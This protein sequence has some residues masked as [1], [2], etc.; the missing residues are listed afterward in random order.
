MSSNGEISNQFEQIWN[1][2]PGAVK[3]TLPSLG[4]VV[5]QI[6]NT[7]IS[8]SEAKECSDILHYLRPENSCSVKQ[9]TASVEKLASNSTFFEANKTECV[10]V[11]TSKNVECPPN[12]GDE[13]T[14]HFQAIANKLLVA[15]CVAGAIQ[16]I[17]QVVTI[18]RLSQVLEDADANIKVSAT[19]KLVIKAK[20]D[21]IKTRL[22]CLDP[23]IAELQNRNVRQIKLTAINVKI[24][25]LG[26]SIT[27]DI[28]EVLNEIASLS[29]VLDATVSKIKEARNV[30]FG[31]AF[32]GASSGLSGALSASALQAIGSPG[33]LAVTGVIAVANILTSAFGFWKFKKSNDKLE[34]LGI[35]ITEV[36]KL[37]FQVVV[38]KAELDQKMDTI[39]N[40]ILE[41]TG[42]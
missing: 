16:L 24:Q 12:I 34:Q 25:L 18:W 9:A 7:G 6:V 19:Q 1:D 40:G 15:S 27:A 14:S 3:Q 23:L 26:K 33:L 5:S 29:N 2:T 8:F 41:L 13:V 39:F 22:P 17:L 37:R 38:L 20:I 32:S 31:A 10:R 11:M 4:A 30:A 36:E 42:D 21:A 28:D 35:E